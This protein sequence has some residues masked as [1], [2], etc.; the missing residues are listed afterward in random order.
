MGRQSK[1]IKKL[2]KNTNINIAYKTNNTIVNILNHNT[3][4]NTNKAGYKFNKSGI[5]QLTC[6][7]CSEKYIG[8][9]GISLYVRFR[10]HFNDFK[11]ENGYSKFAQH[12]I[13]NRHAIGPIDE[14]MNVLHTIK[15]GKSDGHT[16]KSY[17]QRN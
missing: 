17:I 10:E 15:E 6:K 3:C 9:T 2:F 5:Y 4:N 12:L 13:E 14:I 7:D 8:Q 1:L 16:K 11:R